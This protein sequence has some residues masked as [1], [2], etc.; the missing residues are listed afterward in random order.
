MQYS[1]FD[2]LKLLGSLGL[3]LFGMKLMSES[4]QK[5]AGDKLRN[6][7]SAMTSNRFKGILTG[8]V[9][10]AIIQ[11]SSATTVM[12]VSFVNAGLITF[13]ESIGVIM[14]SNIGTTVTSWLIST[15]GFK[16]NISMMVLPLVGLSLPLLFSKNPNRNN[17]GSVI[18][19]FAIIFI[20]LD[21]LN[22]STPD[23]NNNPGI[24]EF[25]TN[26]S[27]YGFGSIVLFV[28]IGT[29]LTMIL[30][31]SSAV[32]A[33]TLVICFNGWVSYE[34]AAAMVLGQNIGTTITANLAALVANTSAK[35]TAMAHLFFNL[36]GVAIVLPFLKP[37]LHA[38]AAAGVN[39][40]LASPIPIEGQ[41][42]QQTAAAI[43]IALA[44]FHTVFNIGNT[45]ILIWF[46]KPLE[47][48]ITKIVRQ[49]DEE[50]EFKL[51][52]ISTG[53][54]STI[55]LSILQARKEM[56]VF[57]GRVEKMF[58]HTHDILTTNSSKK[59]NSLME[60]FKKNETISDQFEVEITAYLAEVSKQDLS[61]GSA[62]IINRMLQITTQI[63]SIADA[64][65]A[66]SK[67]VCRK[68]EGKIKFKDS[69]E[70]ELIEFYEIIEKQFEMMIKHIKNPE[71][72]TDLY[73]TKAMMKE[74]RNYYNDLQQGHFK[75]LKKGVYKTK[76]GVIYAD[77][78]TELLRIGDLSN[79]VVRLLSA[80]EGVK[81]D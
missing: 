48:I 8:V 17:W 55:D 70:Q 13:G 64:C 81:H 10:T 79:H 31:S 71:L 61:T 69:M 46:V 36:I 19:G 15:L 53:L 42:A 29:I 30:Q 43:P 73:A 74:I 25:L 49:K 37:I 3:F 54:L 77:I 65:Y 78:Y 39:Y 22:H 68:L 16:M 4:L 57:T 23:I 11:S 67:N 60:K 35:R 20:G 59:I 1:I 75:N 62:E 33:L 40:G 14:G 80:Q 72:T 38:I 44:V 51:Q 28:I 18:I 32:M 24:L 56:M 41:T 76:T 12:L 45:L 21:F 27:G 58:K 50:E 34:M 63:E 47:N 26:F 7:L 9:I 2:F 5:V 66:V 6:I 52:Y